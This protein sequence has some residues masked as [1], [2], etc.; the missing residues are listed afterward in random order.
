VNDEADVSVLQISWRRTDMHHIIRAKWDFEEVPLDVV[1]QLL[2]DALQRFGGSIV[3][4]YG[5]L[6]IGTDEGVEIHVQTRE[7][8]T[9]FPF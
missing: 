2:V 3:R 8:S 4:L 1:H 7:A 5:V 9:E 6:P